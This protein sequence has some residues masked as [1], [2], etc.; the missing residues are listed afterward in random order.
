[1]NSLPLLL[2]FG[3]LQEERPVPASFEVTISQS[4]CSSQDRSAT[5]MPV[6]MSS[7][8]STSQVDG[9]DDNSLLTDGSWL[10]RPQPANPNSDDL[11]MQELQSGTNPFTL[12]QVSPA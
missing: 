11:E 5:H 12:S 6:S 1:M 7:P 9:D 8:V 10:S 3:L 4:G 2:L